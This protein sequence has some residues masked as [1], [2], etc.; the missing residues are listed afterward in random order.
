MHL[1]DGRHSKLWSSG[2]GFG[3]GL[4]ASGDRDYIEGVATSHGGQHMSQ[5][6]IAIAYEDANRI[7]N[8]ARLASTEV[9]V[10]WQKLKR[11]GDYLNARAAAEL[12]DTLA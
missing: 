9:Y 7:V 8:R 1:L 10:I 2:P 3:W 4:A 5:L 12:G 11:I 6:E